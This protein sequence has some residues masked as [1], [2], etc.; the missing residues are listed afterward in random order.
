MGLRVLVVEDDPDFSAVL[1]EE[2]AEH[3][4]DCLAADSGELALDVLRG[5]GRP[6]VIVLDLGLPGMSGYGFR[7]AQ[8]ADP[9]IADIPV[10]V[11]TGQHLPGHGRHPLQAMAYMLKPIDVRALLAVL[12]ALEAGGE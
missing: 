8:L 12:D 5:F 1:C 6:D 3:G 2:L 9:A 10:I 7:R 11:V 4:H